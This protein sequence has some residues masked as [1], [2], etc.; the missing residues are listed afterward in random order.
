MERIKL[1]IIGG[2][3]IGKV[4]AESIAYHIPEADV[5]TVADLY[6]DSEMSAF[7]KG[8]GVENTVKDPVEIFED[9]EI[10]AVLVCSATNTHAEM[11]IQAARAGKHVFCEKPIAIDV[12]EIQ[13][14]LTE[15][16]KAGVKLQ[17]GFNRRFD[18]NFKAVRDAVSEGKVGEPHIIKITSRD[19]APPPVEY[20]RVS[21]GIFMDM[22]I[23]DFDMF[24][25]LSGSEVEEIYVQG[26]NLVDPAIGEAGDIDT[27]VISIKFTNGVLGCLDISRK[28]AY[29]YDQRA[30]V[31]G[32]KGSVYSRNDTASTAVLST[33]DGITEEKPL[34]FFLQRYMASFTAEMRSFVRAVTS[35]TDVLVNGVDGL[36]PV[37]VA[38]AAAESL[39][40]GRPVKVSY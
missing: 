9:P 19:P 5:K 38:I 4:H 15:V 22:A 31:F 10:Q 13:R 30:E 28:A 7:F 26:A 12:N 25:Y 40:S 36:R 21:G 18:H 27:A 1:G 37:Q 20:V 24:R 6:M 33:V 23:H 17:V 29:G 14:V 16:N 35:G 32:S 2:G 3:R 11:S 39:K 8:L 34:Y